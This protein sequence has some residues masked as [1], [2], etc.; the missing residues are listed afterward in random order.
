MEFSIDN[1]PENQGYPVGQSTVT[2]NTTLTIGDLENGI[3][4]AFQEPVYGPNALMGS[5][6][7]MPFDDNW[8]DTDYRMIVKESPSSGNLMIVNEN[9]VSSNVWGGRFTFNCSSPSNC[10][11]GMGSSQ[12]ASWGEIKSLY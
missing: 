4:L 1:L 2:W 10:E 6:E 11:C 9:Y 5:I 3:S 12:G 7:F 8:I